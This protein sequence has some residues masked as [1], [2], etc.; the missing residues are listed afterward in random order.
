MHKLGDLTLH[1]S[2]MITREEL[3]SGPAYLDLGLASQDA[4]RVFDSTA[5]IH[6]ELDRYFAP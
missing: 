6:A 3:V 4:V 5:A 2:S 1:E